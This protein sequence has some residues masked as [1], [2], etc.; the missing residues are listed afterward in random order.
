MIRAGI[1]LVV[2]FVFVSGATTRAQDA[3]D[4]QVI[5]AVW[6]ALKKENLADDVADVQIRNGAV[7]LIGKARNAY[8]K[9]KAIEVALGVD[10]VEAVESE[11]EVA[12]P[13]SNENFANDLVD[14]VLTYPHYTVFDDIT[15]TLE[16]EGVV[17]LG[18]YVT[19]PFKKDEIEER[20]GRVLGVRELQS[21]IEVLPVSQSDDRLREVLFRNIYGND[22]FVPYANRT[23]PPIHIIVNKGNV[24]LTGAVRNRIEKRQAESIARSTFGVIQFENRLTI[25]P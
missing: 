17:T 24:I 23:H 12:A 21:S 18:G 22:L 11:L 25:S 3:R 13:E 15:F 19:M 9:M 7:V 5:E 6:D 4:Q 1:L 2:A 8:S 10:G 16:D 20:V 14:R